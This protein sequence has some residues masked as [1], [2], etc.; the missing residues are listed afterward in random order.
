[1]K[2]MYNSYMYTTYNNT[3]RYILKISNSACGLKTLSTIIIIVYRYQ[4]DNML[5]P[6]MKFFFIY[7]IQLLGRL[8]SS[9]YFLREIS[10]CLQH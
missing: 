4:Y 7:L 5:T 10:Y 2:V 6:I 9:Y 1:M 8:I 3:S